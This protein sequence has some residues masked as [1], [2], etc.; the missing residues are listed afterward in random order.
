MPDVFS[1]SVN[2]RNPVLEVILEEFLQGVLQSGLIASL[3]EDQWRPNVLQQVQQLPEGRHRQRVIAL[4]AQLQKDG[5]LVRHHKC[6]AGTPRNPNEWR[7]L[8]LE[9]HRIIPFD[10]IVCSHNLMQQANS[11]ENLIELSQILTAS[12]WLKRRRTLSLVQREQDYEKALAP[13]LRHAREL[14]LVDPYMSPIAKNLATVKLCVQAMSNRAQGHARGNI[15]IHECNYGIRDGGALIEEE[16][17]QRFD[18]WEQQLRQILNSPVPHAIQVLIWNAWPGRRPMH[19]RYILTDQCGVQVPA[20]L[21]CPGGGSAKS[22]DWCLLDREA[23]QRR[24]G[25]YP[26]TVQPRDTSTTYEL[27]AR[28]ELRLQDSGDQPA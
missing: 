11:S 15:Y 18:R 4:L 16:P 19:D 2:E 9:S 23:W 26:V 6:D 12:L 1:A 28:R 17:S 3:D 7:A 5:R 20:G 10:G 25:E 24:L 27:I 8:A 13:L 21:E 22:T 14:H